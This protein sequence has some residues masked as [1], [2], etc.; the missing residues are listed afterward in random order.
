MIQVGGYGRSR[1]LK[2]PPPRQ[3][4]NRIISEPL[5]DRGSRVLDQRMALVNKSGKLGV[6]P[7]TV[8]RTSLLLE[9]MAACRGTPLVC[10]SDIICGCWWR[11]WLTMWTF[12]CLIVA[13]NNVAG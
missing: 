11:K 10:S 13:V 9:K 5:S 7:S 4:N 6:Y 3:A 12:A 1:L 8:Y 2:A